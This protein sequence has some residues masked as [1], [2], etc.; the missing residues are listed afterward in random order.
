MKQNK[1]DSTTFMLSYRYRNIIRDNKQVICFLE[2]QI[3][4]QLLDGD[5]S[6]HKS[7]GNDTHSLKQ[8]SESND[9]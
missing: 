7:S 5:M 9:S 3:D 8:S 6:S 2:N 4:D 1:F